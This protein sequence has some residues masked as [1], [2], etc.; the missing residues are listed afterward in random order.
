[1]DPH[2]S[3]PQ[4]QRIDEAWRRHRRHVLDIAF[5]MLGDLGEAEDVVQEAYSRL[6][7][8]EAD[9]IDDPGGWLVVVT[10]RLCLDRLRVRQRRPVDVHADLDDE[11]LGV[12]PDPSDRITLD[13]SVNLALHLMLERLSPAERTAFV[14]HDVFQYPFDEIAA[15]VGR[16]PAACRQLASRGRRALEA[17]SGRAGFPVET[18]EQRQVT[19][20]FI[21]A[22]ATGDLDALV[23]VLAPDVDG[24]GDL[25]RVTVVGAEKVAR[26]AMGYLGPAAAPTMLP[27]PTGDRAGV[28]VLRDGDVAVI[29]LLTIEGGRVTHLEAHGR[30]AARRAVRAVLGEELGRSGS[31]PG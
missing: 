19:Q 20:R 22:C 17:E 25:N 18:V 9:D 7:R 29:L 3:R 24:W 27:I 16:S 26:T 2:R 10:G 12:A 5:R 31:G 1:M 14:L 8:A 28:V 4:D 23:A 15:I 30:P 13:D 6:A 21:D 11:R